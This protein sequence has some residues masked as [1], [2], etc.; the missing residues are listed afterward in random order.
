MSCLKV[1]NRAA[2]T[3]TLARSTARPPGLGGLPGGTVVPGGPV[4][5]STHMGTIG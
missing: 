4:E 3:S 1:S 5:D 2:N